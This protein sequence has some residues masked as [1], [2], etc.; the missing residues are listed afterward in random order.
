MK[1]HRKL[2]FKKRELIDW[3][4]GLGEEARLKKEVNKYESSEFSKEE[5]HAKD[6]STM[7]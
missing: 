6:S 4:D 3:G 2:S 5:S 1:K 7:L